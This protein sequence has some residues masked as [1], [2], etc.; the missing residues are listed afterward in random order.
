MDFFYNLLF[1]DHRPLWCEREILPSD[2]DYLAEC[3]RQGVLNSMEDLEH[4]LQQYLDYHIE[5]KTE[6]A[7]LKDQV[8]ID[9]LVF[10]P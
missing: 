8:G 4:V 9:L 3:F 2:G 7:L 5:T 1:W 10:M 6:L